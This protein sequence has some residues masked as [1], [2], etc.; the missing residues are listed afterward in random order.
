MKECLM[1]SANTDDGTIG[2]L[3]ADLT[4]VQMLDLLPLGA[5][6]IDRDRVVHAWNTTLASWSSVPREDILGTRLTDRYAHLETWCFRER[7]NQVFGGGTPAVFSAAFHRCF[8]PA[9]PPQ[10]PAVDQMIQQT[11]VRPIDDS[12]TKALVII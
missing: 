1:S 12:L 9:R 3:G 5:C 2:R 11:I 6:V 4:L 10:C 8:I 7:L